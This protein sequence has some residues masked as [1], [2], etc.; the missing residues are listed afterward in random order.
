MQ[1][2]PRSEKTSA[3]LL[4]LFTLVAIGW[5]NSPLSHTYLE[6]WSSTIDLRVGAA[7]IELTFREVVNDALMTFFFL[8]VGLEVKREFTIGELTDRSRALVP[9][10]AAI[11]GLIIPAFVFL[12]VNPTGENAQAWGVVISTDTAFLVGAL[13]IAGPKFPT[14]L[15]LFLLTLAVVDDVGALIVIA[16][17]YTD[18]VQ[19]APLLLALICLVIVALVRF[20][21]AGRGLAYAF[22]AVIIW[23]SLFAAGVHPT[24]TGVA[25]A[26]LIPVFPPK[27]L[28]V[29]RAVTLTHAFEQSPSSH[30]ARAA[31]RGLRDSISISERLH[32]EYAP[33]VAYIILPIF[34]L[35][36][37]GVRLDGKTLAAAVISPL[38][39]GIVAGLVAGKLLGITA[40]TAI[41]RALHVGQLA[42]GLTVGR[43]AGGAALSG[44]GFTISLLIVDIAIADP[45]K[46]DE[47]RVG[48]LAASVAALL[49]G[50]AI[51]RIVDR[52]Q[53]PTAIGRT[54]VRPVDAGR[55]H[56][57]GNPDAPL[58]LVEY[59]D[60]ECSFCSHASG[61]IDE[62][63]AYFGADLRYVWRHLPTSREHPHA[64]EAAYASEA[65]ALH[66]KFFELL[67]IMFSHQDHLDSDDLY[68]YAVELG[69]DTDRFASNMRSAHVANRVSDD[70][71]DAEL[72]DLNHTPTFF[73]G[74]VRHHGPY[75]AATLIQALEASRGIEQGDPRYK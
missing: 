58:T 10:S 63:R 42:P 62:I 64:L 4:I 5:A 68:T 39:W 1:A 74:E 13:A 50:W 3:A 16:V 49:L 22:L 36:N 67:P 8:T 45:V 30:Y 21:R 75:D 61:S 72:M 6:F 59:G 53:P 31:T 69:L 41:L 43:V 11:A 46:Q 27:R 23:F 32:S 26:L 70:I 15:R 40:I 18:D 57:L 24:L 2:P 29:E 56:I 65:A 73:V 48:V 71:L 55:D 28:A 33:Y 35:A 44:I 38:T 17:F 20:L 25:L 9:I 37:A 52:L 19:L 47:A 34:A 60:F 54:L 51:F 14:R 12:V 7:S 66:D